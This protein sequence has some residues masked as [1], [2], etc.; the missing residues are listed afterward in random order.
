MSEQQDFIRKEIQALDCE[1]EKAKEIISKMEKRPDYASNKTYQ[2]QYKSN[3]TTNEW[4]NLGSPVVSTVSSFKSSIAVGRWVHRRD[5]PRGY[6]FVLLERA[7]HAESRRQ[8]IA[9][10]C[11]PLR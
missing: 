9:W 10:K 2:V 5:V 4:T 8:T 6:T 1:I 3:L 7:A 11:R